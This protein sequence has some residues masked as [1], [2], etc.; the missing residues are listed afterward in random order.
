MASQQQQQPRIVVLGGSIAGVL[1]IKALERALGRTAAITMV[2][3]RDHFFVPF[4]GLRA[5]VD[6]D[7]AP[8]VWVPYS[9]LFANLP[10]ARIIRARAVRVD[11][12]A[13]ALDNGTTV[14]FDY[15]IVATG[16]AAGGIGKQR[17]DS[18]DAGLAAAA[19][20]SAAIRA[21]GSV[22]IVGGGTVGIELAAEVAEAVPGVKEI[23]LIHSGPALLSSEPLALEKTRNA[24][25]ASMNSR[26]GSR[27]KVHLGRPVVA[28]S[29]TDSAAA[30]VDG[31]VPDPASGLSLTPLLLHLGGDGAAPPPIRA[32]VTILCIGASRPNSAAVAAGLGAEALTPSGRVHVLPSG[33]LPAHP[34]RIFALGDVADLDPLTIAQVLTSQSAVVAANL[35]A[36]VKAEQNG[37]NPHADPAKWKHSRT[38]TP[39]TAVAI[40]L[41]LGKSGGVTQL[42]FGGFVVGDFMTRM[43]KAKDLFVP[44]WWSNLNQTFKP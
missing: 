4:G 26:F 7:F 25:V 34:T 27:F 44:T 2:E 10:N 30:R 19:R 35:V 38:Y 13:V 42:P 28:H 22:A 20:I 40:A 5:L 41:P 17:E 33:S 12:R 1:V 8:R 24:V 14:E 15:C 16:A 18:R 3:P 11:P 6:P 9:R 31:P 21:A 29:S 23:H 39:A 32:D 36:V 37:A 43:I